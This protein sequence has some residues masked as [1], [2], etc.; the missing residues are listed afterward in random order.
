MKANEM[1]TFL[2]HKP[3]IAKKKKKKE[4]TQFA[5]NTSLMWDKNLQEM[6][7]LL[8]AKADTQI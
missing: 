2:I 5:C 4:S 7:G 1:K 6:R 8:K 3:L